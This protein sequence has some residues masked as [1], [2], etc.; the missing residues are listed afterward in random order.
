MKS[1]ILIIRRILEGVRAKNLEATILFVDVTKA[2]S[3]IHRMKMEQILLAH[4]LPKETVAAKIFVYR[5]T[6]LKACSPN[7]DTDYF[8]IVASVL[9]GDTLTPYLFLISLDYVIR[10]SIDK[11]KENR[12]Q[13][14]KTKKQK[15]PCKNNYRWY[16][17]PGT[18]I[19][20]TLLHS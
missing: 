12:Y 17:A 19:R 3:S 18:C 9:Q 13:A 10:T 6:K 15:I 20:S 8:D 14:N 5:N 4:G 16:S 7:G 1:Q 2:L 11:I